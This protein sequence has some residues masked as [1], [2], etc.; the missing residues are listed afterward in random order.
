MDVNISYP[1]KMIFGN[2]IKEIAANLRAADLTL[3]FSLMMLS[4]ILLVSLFGIFLYDKTF[5]ISKKRALSIKTKTL[6]SLFSVFLFF[7]IFFD[8]L[9]PRILIPKDF[10]TY[11]KRLPFFYTITSYKSQRIDSLYLGGKIPSKITKPGKFKNPNFDNFKIQKSQNSPNIFIFIIEALRKD[12]ITKE[13][14]PTLFNF[15]NE[16]IC[17]KKSF[18][19][20]NGTG[21]SWFSIFYSKFP[22]ILTNSKNSFK[23]SPPLKILKNL[24]YK[25]NI[26]SAAELKY[27]NMDKIIFGEN[28]EL[29]DK[30]FEIKNKKAYKRDKKAF[31]L[32]KENISK[33]KKLYITFLDSTHSEYS[34]PEK[35]NA[36][37]KAKFKPFCKSINYLNLSYFKKDILL[38]KNRYLNSVNF[39]DSLFK[40]FFEFLKKKKLYKDA[41]IVITADHGEEFFEEGSLFH[42]THLNDYQIKIPILY[43]LPNEKILNKNKLTSLVDIFP[44]ILHKITNIENFDIFDGRSILSKEETPFIISA[45]QNGLNPSERFAIFYKNKKILTDLTKENILNIVETSDLK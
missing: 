36:K 33:N 12:I 42:G 10:I 18:A 5:K 23:G 37:F 11:K 26:F 40:S 16:N 29:A 24:G 39:L 1:Y 28:K 13:I 38:V 3:S 17:L 8:M 4:I 34:F 21:G 25:I 7:N 22:H 43:K 44:T 45:C 20:A 19:N 41:I 32:L 2:G 27:F 30:F 35:F 9:I 14:T 15:K 31:K 6:F